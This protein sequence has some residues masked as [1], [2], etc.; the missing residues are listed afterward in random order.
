MQDSFELLT[1]YTSA[2]YALAKDPH[3]G[4]VC[5]LEGDCAIYVTEYEDV[6]WLK[7]ITPDR[8]AFFRDG[9]WGVRNPEGEIV[10][11]DVF[12]SIINYHQS[13]YLLVQD[14]L[15]KVGCVDKD[16]K[17]ILPCLYTDVQAREKLE[18]LI[19][20]ENSSLVR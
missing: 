17:C 20:N 15:G 16:F 3:S 2:N 12:K 7:W 6:D 18:Q 10:I 8:L 9:H 4:R 13:G 14:P 5:V 1:N 11:P 19:N